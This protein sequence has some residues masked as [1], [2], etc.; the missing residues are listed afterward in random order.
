LTSSP[1]SAV[2]WFVAEP[3]TEPK[4]LR[5]AGYFSEIP[6]NLDLLPDRY[7][8]LPLYKDEIWPNV[9]GASDFV[10]FLDAAYF[11]SGDVSCRPDGSASY[12]VDPALNTKA[13]R[14]AS[15]PRAGTQARKTKAQS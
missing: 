8:N 15:L 12:L 2:F 14:M 9:Q 6:S 5:M 1:R 13:F 11:P 7:F 3:G 10:G 4:P